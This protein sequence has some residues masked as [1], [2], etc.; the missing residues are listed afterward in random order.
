MVGIA[1]RPAAVMST[2]APAV[3]FP[4]NV[5]DNAQQHTVK[6][7]H[8]PYTHGRSAAPALQLV[9]PSLTDLDIS[10]RVFPSPAARIM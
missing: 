2:A 6:R 8:R 10:L 5:D 3:T 7:Q 4:L 1:A 9:S